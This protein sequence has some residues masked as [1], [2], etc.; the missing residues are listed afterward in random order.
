[1]KVTLLSTDDLIPIIVSS[2]LFIFLSTIHKTL[3]SEKYSSILQFRAEEDIKRTVSSTVI[4]IIYIILGTYFLYSIC[5]YSEKQ[6]VLGIFIVTFLN[7]WPAIIQNHLLKFRNN[8]TEW[9]LL[10]H[11]IIFVIVSIT[12]CKLTITI[13]IPVL[14]GAKLFVFL[15]N[16]AMTFIISLFLIAF[17]IELEK[18]IDKLFRVVII[19][20]ADSYREELYILENQ[21]NMKNYYIEKNKIIIDSVAR[22]YDINI[23]I[24]EAI[25]KLEIFYRR[26]LFYP[27]F[28]KILCKYFSNYAIKKDISVGIAQIKISTAEKILNKDSREFIKKICYDDMNIDVCARLIKLLIDNYENKNSDFYIYEFDIYQYISLEY[29]GGCF[30]N[31]T[32]MLY[33]SILRGVMKNKELYYCGM[34]DNRYSVIITKENIIREEYNKLKNFIDKLE[35][36]RKIEMKKMIFIENER[37]DIEIICYSSETIKEIKKNLEKK[38]ICKV[39]II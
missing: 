17:P 16:K 26:R 28:E 31:K 27:I 6:I 25:L 11:Y 37:I 32:M 35:N 36:S 33:S 23:D 8:T 22:K 14:K 19:E 29:L 9:S 34:G 4:R 30:M 24:L 1:M 12:I 18:I 39:N 15:D 10:L 5:N 21:L 13:F 20:N 2:I 38:Y 7:I 3:I